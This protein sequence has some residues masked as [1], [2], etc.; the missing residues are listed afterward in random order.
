MSMRLI[1]F[2][3]AIYALGAIVAFGHSASSKQRAHATC[4]ANR[5]LHPDR[6]ILCPD[7]AS[8]GIV[9]GALWPFYLS[10]E[11]WS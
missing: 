7:P 2:A 1:A 8:Y 6:L 4:E 3:A 5:E 9:A 11:I 10:W